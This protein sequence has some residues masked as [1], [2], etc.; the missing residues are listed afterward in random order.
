MCHGKLV[1]R[2]RFCT[3]HSDWNADWSFLISSRRATEFCKAFMCFIQ[4]G[5]KL[6]TS[7]PVTRVGP[8]D[9]SGFPAAASGEE[10]LEGEAESQPLGP[11][12]GLVIG[13]SPNG[14]K[15]EA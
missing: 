4:Q 14:E 1:L 10:L 3:P 8:V 9:D 12:D 11:D 15:R 13:G 5:C 7:S 6:R 2:E